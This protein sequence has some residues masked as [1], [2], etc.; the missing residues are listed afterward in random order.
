M[1]KLIEDRTRCTVCRRWLHRLFAALLLLAPA[2]APA[3]TYYVDPGG[4]DAADGSEGTPW[5]TIQKAADEVTAGDTVIV[6][7]GAYDEGG[8]LTLSASGTSEAPITFRA[9]NLHGAKIDSG[10][11]CD[12]A[13]ASTHYGI[14]THNDGVS[15]VVVEGFEILNWCQGIVVGR[16]AADMI[17]RRNLIH[18]IG[19]VCDDGTYAGTGLGGISDT[20]RNAAL[21]SARITYD[22]NT[23]HTIGRLRTGESGCAEES[24]PANLD[25]GLYIDGDDFTVVNNVFVEFSSGYAIQLANGANGAVIAHNTFIGKNL[26]REGQLLLWNGQS[27]IAIVNNISFDSSVRFVRASDDVDGPCDNKTAIEI[28]ANLVSVSEVQTDDCG[29]FALSGNVVSGDPAFVDDTSGA[30]YPNG[31]YRLTLAS[32]AIGLGLPGYAASDHLGGTRDASP[33]A[34]AYER[35][36]TSGGGSFSGGVAMSGGAFLGRV[37]TAPVGTS[38]EVDSDCAAILAGIWAAT[39]YSQ[40]LEKPAEELING[41]G[42]FSAFDP[43]PKKR[44]TPE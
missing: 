20:N 30:D 15:W 35:L 25:H 36:L 41:N 18:S 16:S 40:P 14:V 43:G 17:F 27:N 5:L 37:A 2:F 6:R 11:A 9:E 31:D 7:D 39:G 13:D 42:C 4:S 10:S 19:R 1:K 33:D 44:E 22:S 8:D 23:F 12:D 28:R 21:P 38:A 32:D 34:G 29:A 24:I 26:L 3:A